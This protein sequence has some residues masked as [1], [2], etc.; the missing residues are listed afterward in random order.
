MADQDETSQQTQESMDE[1]ALRSTLSALD[2]QSRALSR[3]IGAAKKAKADNADELIAEKKRLQLEQIQPLKDQLERLAQQDGGKLNENDES[4]Q[5]QIEATKRNIPTKNK[6]EKSKT[7]VL[8][9]PAPYPSTS[10]ENKEESPEEFEITTLTDL[11]QLNED[12]NIYAKAHPQGSIYHQ[13]AFLNSLQKTFGHRVLLFC[14]RNTRSNELVALLPL[15]EQKSPLFRHLW[16]SI[17]F[18]NY[19]GVLADNAI[20]ENKLLDGVRQAGKLAGIKRLEI[21]GLYQRPVDWSV[22]TEKA[23]MWLPLPTDHSSDTLLKQFKAKLRSQIKKGY[24]PEVSYKTGTLELLNDFYAVFARNMR[25]LG[26]PVYTKNLFENLLKD[27]PDKAHIVMVYHDNKP[28]SAAFLIKNRDMME[29]PWAS[30]IREYNRYNLNMVLYWEVLKLSCAQGC[31]V[32][33]FGRSTIDATTYKFKKQWGAQP[34]QH[35]WYSYE[36]HAS[37]GGNRA[38]NDNSSANTN[39]PKFQLLI[40][41]W[42]RLPLWLANLVGPHIVKDIP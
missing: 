40:Q 15:I 26:T 11:A 12:W 14:L 9:A 36:P 38:Q 24:T 6:T 13:T 19:G 32:F 10:L 21:R 37:S 30:T 1:E 23:S 34:I 25:D 31:D 33:D 27:L 20:I 18:V 29:I 16:T 3:K 39:N 22:S 2:E 41:V 5:K 4:D 42:K 7:I 28:A 35:Y 17:A 8:Q